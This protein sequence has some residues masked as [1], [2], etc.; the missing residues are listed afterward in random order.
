MLGIIL[1]DYQDLKD[2]L[3]EN[4]EYYGED[5]RTTFKNKLLL[6]KINKYKK[7]IIVLIIIFITSF[8][9]FLL[10]R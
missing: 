10:W 4:I 6:K 5:E 1:V 8:T 7:I 9:L 3:K 2:E